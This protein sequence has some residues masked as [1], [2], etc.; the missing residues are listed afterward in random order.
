MGNSGPILLNANTTVSF[1]C[2]LPLK[3]KFSEIVDIYSVDYHGYETCNATL[4]K[5]L[6]PLKCGASH[7]NKREA[8]EFTKKK[9]D[10]YYF[11]G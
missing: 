8:L 4:G 9:A 5:L 11:I 6:G 1:K 10:T 3:K 2:K 7:N